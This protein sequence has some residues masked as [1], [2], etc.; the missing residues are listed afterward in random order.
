M[1]ENRWHLSEVVQ[2][3]QED[4]KKLVKGFS[5]G[6]IAAYAMGMW[7]PNADIV[8]TAQ[9]IKVLVD[10][11][12]ISADAVDVT[13]AGSELKVH[14][15]HAEED[16]EG[17]KV[18]LAERRRGAFSRTFSLPASVDPKQ[19]D[20]TVKDGLLEV[21]FPKKPESQPNEIKVE[22]K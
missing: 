19:V 7:V 11:P 12:G 10:L 15:R 5:D 17:V 3:I 13:L 1:K 2:K 22:V 16:M 20:A 6:D 21:T 14:G 9:E 18:H 4:V 8:E